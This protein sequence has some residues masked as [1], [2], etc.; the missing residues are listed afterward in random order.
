METKRPADQDRLDAKRGAAEHNKEGQFAIPSSPAHS[1]AKF[2]LP[3]VS[4]VDLMAF[5]LNNSWSK[6]ASR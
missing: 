2:V 1:I 3:L 6:P 4:V 5:M